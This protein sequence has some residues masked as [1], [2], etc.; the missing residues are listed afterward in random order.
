MVSPSLSQD[1]LL[2]HCLESTYRVGKV[3]SGG[4][5]LGHC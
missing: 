5:L 2:G 1:F 3:G 4:F